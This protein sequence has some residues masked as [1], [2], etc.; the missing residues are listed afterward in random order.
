VLHT[1]ACNRCKAS[2]VCLL[3]QAT[4]L[5]LATRVLADDPDAH[6]RAMAVEVVG[7]W[8]HTDV[9]A[10]D[11]LSRVTNHDPSPAVRKKARWFAPGGP[12]YLRTQP[13]ARRQPRTS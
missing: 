11:A 7:R 5:P 8:V 13:K 9:T 4:I 3:D 1:L 6:V 12:I 2:D 10:A